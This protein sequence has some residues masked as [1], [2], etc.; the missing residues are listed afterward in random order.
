MSASSG[1]VVCV[2]SRSFFFLPAPEKRVSLV[3]PCVWQPSEQS[4]CAP[5][6]IQPHLRIVPPVW[7]RPGCHADGSAV[8]AFVNC[9]SLMTH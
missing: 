1:G 5:E 2:W 7:N 8:F 9:Y 6:T 3:A 4:S